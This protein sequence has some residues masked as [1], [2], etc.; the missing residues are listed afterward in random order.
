VPADAGD[1]PH[2]IG[3][4]DSNDPKHKRRIQNR[5]ASAR[6]RAKAKERQTELDR[7]KSQVD[8]KPDVANR[9]ND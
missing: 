8:P 6:F 5:L 2:G 1:D 9:E 7:L 3:D 4:L